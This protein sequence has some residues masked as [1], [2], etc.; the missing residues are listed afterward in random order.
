M[1]LLVASV[2]ADRLGGA[3]AKLWTLLRHLDL[4]RIQPEVIFFS[5]GPFEREVAR[6]GI[7][8]HVLPTTRLRHGGR[9][10]ETIR[11]FRGLIRSTRPDV[12][13]AWGVK[14]Q[15]YAGP[16][17]LSTGTTGRLVWWQ[18]ELPN[19]P[20]HRLATALPAA[21][22]G[23]SSHFVADAQARTWPRR[24]TFVVHP[25]IEDPPVADTAALQALRVKLGVPEGRAVV[26]TI[27]RLVPVKGQHHL[28]R[29]L[30][31][32]RASGHD[33]HG[34]FVG[35]N[36]HDLA[37]EYGPYLERLV[38][39]LGLRDAVTFA[40]QVPNAADHL[41]LMDVFVSTAPD[42]GFGIALV[43]AL[44]LRVPLV[45][46]DAGGP[47]EIV[48]HGVSGL[49]VPSTDT[50]PLADAIGSILSDARLAAALA[51]G[52]ERRFRAAF[53]AARM[54]DTLSARLAEIA[55]A[56]D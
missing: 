14:A 15:L 28:L 35:G 33:V 34:L 48:E 19:H 9:L 13:L 42:E 18:T 47:R 23:C 51:E 29:A 25:G 39:E 2:W 56:R 55:G 3:E 41:A 7:R 10:V 17:A 49:L 32:L 22:I 26:G 30:A 27:G 8:T 20:V 11:A 31:R 16:A 5:R 12:V 52:G 45:A 44:A 50:D 36:A 53:T 6:L 21:A 54:A 1:R 38:A 37:P 40:G 43:E 24:R 46:I 4:G